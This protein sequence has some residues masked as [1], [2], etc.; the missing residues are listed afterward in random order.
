MLYGTKKKVNIPTPEEIAEMSLVRLA[1]AWFAAGPETGGSSYVYTQVQTPVGDHQRTALAQV[2]SGSGMKVE[3]GCRRT[4]REAETD[5]GNFKTQ[6]GAGRRRSDRRPSDQ[7]EFYLWYR[8][9]LSLF[10]LAL[11]LALL[12]PGIASAEAYTIADQNSPVAA[13]SS[14]GDRGR[15]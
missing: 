6:K 2:V 3:A 11:L 7:L 1:A 5:N 8:F 14:K 10:Y 4:A 15:R 12:M 13:H 9:I